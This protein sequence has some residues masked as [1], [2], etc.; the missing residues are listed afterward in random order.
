MQI[1]MYSFTWMIVLMQ[2]TSGE[3]RR[4]PPMFE[5]CIDWLITIPNSSL[6]VIWRVAVHDNIHRFDLS[7]AVKI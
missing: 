1:H 5:F 3:I 2:L 6:I 4:S 7:L